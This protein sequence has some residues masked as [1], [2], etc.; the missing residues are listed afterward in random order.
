MDSIPAFGNLSFRKK[1]FYLIYK[2]L[3]INEKE[4]ATYMATLSKII[5]ALLL[6]SCN[7]RFTSWL[8]LALHEMAIAYVLKKPVL[9]GHHFS[10]LGSIQL[11][12]SAERTEA[13]V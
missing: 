12:W 2:N 9:F 13:F 4:K 5:I 6:Y 7:R 1:L 8:L 10:G 11:G 3:I